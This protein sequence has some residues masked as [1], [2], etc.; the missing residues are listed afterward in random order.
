MVSLTIILLQIIRYS[1]L[2]YTKELGHG[3]Y[4]TVYHGKWKGSDVAI[5]RMKPTCSGKDEQLV[6]NIYSPCYIKKMGY[7]LDFVNILSSN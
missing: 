3:T 5:K 2:E 1:D 7:P 6:S 4:G